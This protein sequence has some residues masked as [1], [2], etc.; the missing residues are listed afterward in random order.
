MAEEMD[1]NNLATAI[2]K[3]AQLSRRT[4]V[5][6]DARLL[7]LM[8]LSQAETQRWS[9]RQLCHVA[10]SMATLQGPAAGKELLAGIREP[11]TARDGHLTWRKV[12]DIA[13]ESH[14]MDT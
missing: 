13:L 6:N 5:S 11:K 10:W 8:R 3:V 14:L 7:S 2:H 4:A 1:A 12:E 9:C